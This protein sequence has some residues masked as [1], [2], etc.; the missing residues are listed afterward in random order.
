MKG[1]IETYGFSINDRMRVRM[2]LAFSLYLSCTKSFALEAPI[3]V[4]KVFFTTFR[5]VE[6]SRK[7]VFEFNEKVRLIQ[8]KW[9]GFVHLNNIRKSILRQKWNEMV[10]KMIKQHKNKGKIQGQ[11]LKLNAL[12]TTIHM[13]MLDTYFNIKKT[14]YYKTIRETPVLFGVNRIEDK[15]DECAV[16]LYS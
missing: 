5:G 10:Q 11:L 13:P 3:S 6:L 14:K 15:E 12:P 4:L 7:A 9:R 8:I 2:A 16:W 1:N